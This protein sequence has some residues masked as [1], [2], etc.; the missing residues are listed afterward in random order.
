M[1]L[2]VFFF[3]CFSAIDKDIILSIAQFCEE[4][5]REAANKT[6]KVNGIDVPVKFLNKPVS[7]LYEDFCGKYPGKKISS[8]SFR[9][10]IPKYFQKG[11]EKRT[12]MCSYCV[13]GK[14]ALQQ[15]KRIEELHGHNNELSAEIQQKINKVIF[16]SFNFCFLK[17]I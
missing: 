15:I 17:P 13:H 11:G 16:L 10:Y 7:R 3:F 5:S 4:N 1:F 2:I 14:K 8:S 6:L 9:K 12:D